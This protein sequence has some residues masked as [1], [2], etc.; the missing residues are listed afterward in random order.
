MHSVFNQMSITESMLLSA[1]L[2]STEFGLT[3]GLEMMVDD[4]HV[5]YYYLTLVE[6]VAECRLC[7]HIHEQELLGCC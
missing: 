4:L 6:R 7:A 3:A 5:L 1:W 2:M